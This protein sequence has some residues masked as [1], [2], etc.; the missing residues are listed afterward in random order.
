M[1]V[2]STILRS[3]YNDLYVSI[4]HPNTKFNFSLPKNEVTDILNETITNIRRDLCS[5]QDSL[6]KTSEIEPILTKLSHI[7]LSSID[8]IKGENVSTSDYNAILMKM[9]SYGSDIRLDL[10]IGI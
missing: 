9:I 6:I 8:E 3:L 2:S 1:I 5:H 7:I 10:S 4:S